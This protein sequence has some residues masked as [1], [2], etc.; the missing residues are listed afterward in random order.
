MEWIIKDKSS[1][2]NRHWIDIEAK[3]NY[4]TSVNSAKTGQVYLT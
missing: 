4:H 2:Q 3:N 1:K